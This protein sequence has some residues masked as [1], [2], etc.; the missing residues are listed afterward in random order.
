[1]NQTLDVEKELNHIE[2]ILE[3]EKV[4]KRLFRLSRD[5]SFA[6]ALI[7]TATGLTNDNIFIAGPLVTLGI[8]YGVSTVYFNNQYS[9]VKEN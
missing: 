8:G 4:G 6:F 1:M 3:G 9:Q 2:Y 5:V 7:T